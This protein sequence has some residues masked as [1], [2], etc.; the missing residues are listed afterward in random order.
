MVTVSNFL[1]KLI[2]FVSPDAALRRAQ[3][4]MALSAASPVSYGKSI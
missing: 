1:D 2:A 4:R 3:A